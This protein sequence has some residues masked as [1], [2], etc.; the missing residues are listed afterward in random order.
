MIRA[1]AGLL[2][3]ASLAAVPAAAAAELHPL[4]V[5]GTTLVLAAPDGWTAALPADG[6]TLR[7][8]RPA[9]DAGL[10]VTVSVLG[11]REGQAGFTQ[12]SLDD[13]QRLLFEFDLRD[14]DFDAR[15]G[16]RTWSRLHYRFVLGETRW[17][18]ELWLT[19]ADDQAVAV[20]FTASPAAWAAWKPV[21]DRCIAEAGASRPVLT[22]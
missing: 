15:S 1:A 14:W 2:L 11:P 21:F 12:R 17:E 4:P 18:Q 22:R 7:L 9:G 16:S 6:T 19:V 20:A 13:L 3:L 5:P 8:R 10:A